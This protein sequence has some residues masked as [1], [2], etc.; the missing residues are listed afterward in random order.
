MSIHLFKVLLSRREKRAPLL[1]RR[2]KGAPLLS[3]REKGAPLLPSNIEI[4]SRNIFL[5]IIG[6]LSSNSFLHEKSNVPFE[7]TIFFFTI[8]SSGFV[9]S[10]YKNIKTVDDCSNSDKLD[11]FQVIL[12]LIL[13][14]SSSACQTFFFPNLTGKT[15]GKDVKYVQC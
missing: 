15:L 2:E 11:V 12:H 5:A 7:F 9:N 6:C 8:K 13:S 4:I 14:N 10:M 1:S 3:R